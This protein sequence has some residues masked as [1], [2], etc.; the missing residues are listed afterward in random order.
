LT[1]NSCSICARG[2]EQQAAQ[3][4]ILYAFAAELTEAIR[5]DALSSRC[6]RVLASVCREAK[7][8][9]F[10][11]TVRADFP[12]LTGRSTVS[13][14][15]S[16]QRR[17][18]AEAEAVI[19]AEAEFYRHGYAACTRYP[20]PERGGHARMEQVQ[21]APVSSTPGRR[22]SWFSSAAPPKASTWWPTAGETPTSARG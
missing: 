14:W 3:Q 17:Q 21:Q 22:K 6:W 9:I 11:R 12:V 7:H 2:I 4:M 16:R 20:Y 15:L 10:R 18:R 5:D 8:D 19:D 13:R 1:T